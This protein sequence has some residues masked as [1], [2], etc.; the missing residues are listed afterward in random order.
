MQKARRYP[1]L[2]HR[3]TT[4]CKWLGSGS[5]HSPPGVLF[6]FRSRYLCTVGLSGVCRL[7]A[8]APQIH[9]GLHESCVTQVPAR[10]N[11][12]SHTGLSPAVAH[13]SRCFCSFVGPMS[14][15][16]QPQE[17]SFLV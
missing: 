11:F 10:A 9:A 12:P 15:A 16:L 3:A 2:R 5:F 8:W 17:A 1:A 4:A 7:G 14:P 13:L 6:S